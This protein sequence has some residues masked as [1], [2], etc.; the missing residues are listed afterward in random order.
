MQTFE[1]K[2]WIERGDDEVLVAVTA[3]YTPGCDEV[4]YLPNGDPGY[5]A[6]PSDVSIVSVVG[7]NGVE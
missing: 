2:L 7:D 3:D 6:E 4:R 1:T 5:P